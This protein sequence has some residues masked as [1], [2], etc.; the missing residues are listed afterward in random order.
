MSAD[1]ISL[2]KARKDREKAKAARTTAAN[3]ARFG[4]SKAQKAI[5]KAQEEFRL[6]RLDL[7]RRDDAGQGVKRDE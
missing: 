3:R 1:I 6:R 4:R 7:A 2:S 5:E